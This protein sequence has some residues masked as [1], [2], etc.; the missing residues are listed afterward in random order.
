[1]TGILSDRHIQE[2]RG[3]GLTDETIRAAGPYSGTKEK[4]EAV[5]G[6]SVFSGGLCYPYPGTNGSGPAFTRVKPDVPF[7]DA[8]GK[9]A[10]YLTAK[11]AGNRLYIPPFYSERHFKDSR[12]PVISTEGEK[13][14]LKG[15][16]DLEGFI[17]LGLAGVWCFKSKDR[18]LIE[19]F[20][21]FNWKDRTVYVCF[22]SDVVQKEEVQR[23]ECAFAAELHK[24]GAD[25]HI[26]RIPSSQTGK[27]GLDDYLMLHSP[28]TFVE[29]ILDRAMLWTTKGNLEVDDIESFSVKQI[30]RAE[31]IVG[32]GMLPAKGILMIAAY[33]K[34]G[35]S[36][37]AMN[38]GL[39]IAAGK[40]FLN[41]FPIPS[42]RRV[43]L[44]NEEI[45]PQSMQSRSQK[46]VQSARSCGFKNLSNFRLVNKTGIKLDN[47]EGLKTAMRLIRAHKP[48]VVIW[49]CLYRLHGMN[50]NKASE[51][52]GLLDKFEYLTRVFG[53]A[54][55]IVHHFGN[56]V[57]DSD[58][59][60][61]QLMRGSSVFGAY[62]DSYLTVASYKRNE[63][64][65]HY[66]RLT[67]TFRNAETPEDLVISR[68][69]D[70]LWY[71]VVKTVG[72]DQ[73]LTVANVVFTLKE[74]GGRACRKELLERLSREYGV[75]ERT[76]DSVIA[77]AF[78][79]NRIGKSGSTKNCEYFC[80]D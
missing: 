67:F 66:Q 55:V 27:V 58:R 31:E 10:K 39:C 36:I 48:E 63:E 60:G 20:G 42:S 68:N 57:K 46:M 14:A 12:I 59:E 34:K 49:D 17:V 35:K 50:E 4:V 64:K 71:E 47:D 2:L 8:G 74:M 56:P 6:F 45:T 69:P 79:L 40:P 61:F 54:H 16:Q 25:V 44:I 7:K 29:Q 1:M 32:G 41:Q 72:P 77:E 24:K 19:D 70:T 28:E 23:A 62:G 26:C 21:L 13:K 43:L 75:K 15:A 80:H 51:M 52:Q 78:T 9:I 65:S 53:I 18:P 73:K 33:S 30:P 5:L 38:M 76:I 11:N 37:L 22:D 3:S